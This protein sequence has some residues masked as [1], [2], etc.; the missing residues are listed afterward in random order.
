MNLTCVQQICFI[1]T[2]TL[3]YNGPGIGLLYASKVTAEGVRLPL[4]VTANT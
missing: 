1:N 3:K 4:V 2:G